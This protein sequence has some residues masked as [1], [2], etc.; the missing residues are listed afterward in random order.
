MLWTLCVLRCGVYGF[1]VTRCVGRFSCAAAVLGA[2]RRAHFADRGG[3]VKDWECMLKG[4][5]VIYCKKKEGGVRWAK[6]G[7]RSYWDSNPGRRNQNPD[8]S[9]HNSE[10]RAAVMTDYA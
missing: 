6:K 10:E 9:Q 5:S 1:L 8:A 2:A 4:G 7:K 3:K